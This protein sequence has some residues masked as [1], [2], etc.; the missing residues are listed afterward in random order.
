MD[1]IKKAIALQNFLEGDRFFT[2]IFS[3][4]FSQLAIFT[5]KMLSD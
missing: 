5:D 3:S 1:I 4:L 2:A